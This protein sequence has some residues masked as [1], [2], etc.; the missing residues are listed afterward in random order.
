MPHSGRIIFVIGTDTGVGKTVFTALITRRLRERGVHVAALKPLCSGGRDD[1]HALRAAAGNVLALDDV[2]PWHFRA[3]LAPLSAARKENKTVRLRD[4]VSFIRK[5][6]KRFD[7]V[8]VEGAGGLLSPLG[9]GFDA[10]DGLVALKATP[11]L[12]CPNRLG[13]VNQVRLVLGCLPDSLAQQAQVVLMS[14]P[15]ANAASRS[16]VDLL[17]EFIGPNRLHILP[18]LARPKAVQPNPETILPPLDRLIQVLDAAKVASIK[19]AS[20]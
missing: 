5:A 8:V 16:N 20:L 4:V 2:N 11:I 13:A 19:S 14:P 3:P 17:G 18:W 15:R 12:V 10:R 9:E 6:Q 1:A 7:T